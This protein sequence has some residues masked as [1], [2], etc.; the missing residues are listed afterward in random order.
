MVVGRL[1][2]DANP[3]KLKPPN[4]EDIGAADKVVDVVKGLIGACVTG[5]EADTEG[6]PNPDGAVVVFVGLTEGDHEKT[7]VELLV[8]VEAA[9]GEK[10]LGCPNEP[11]ESGWAVCVD[12]LNGLKLGACGLNADVSLASAVC[13]LAFSAKKSASLESSSIVFAESSI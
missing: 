9:N 5:F 2:L 13:L 1:K 4:G 11:V 8:V 6:S 7:G 12:V 10:E 3:S